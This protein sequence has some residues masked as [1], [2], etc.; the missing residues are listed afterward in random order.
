MKNSYNRIFINKYNTKE[1]QYCIL[2]ETEKEAQDTVDKP[3]DYDFIAREYIASEK[4]KTIIYWCNQNIEDGTQV[5][6]FAIQI[7]DYIQSI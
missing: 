3:F 2:F 7:R 1:G 4:L 6:T 5:A